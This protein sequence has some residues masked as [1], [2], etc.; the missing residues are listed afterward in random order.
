MPIKK[1][2]VCEFIT[3]G[4]LC[5]ETLP[6]SLVKEGTLIRDALLQDLSELSYEVSTTYDVRFDAPVLCATCVAVNKNDDVW[7]IWQLQMQAAD[8]VWLIAPET[9]D[10]LKKLT[11]MAEEPKLNGLQ[12]QGLSPQNIPAKAGYSYVKGPL[13]LGCGTA[14]IEVTSNK[15]ATYLALEAAGIPSIPTYNFEDWPKRHWIWLAKPN[16]GV[17]CS[18]TACFNNPDDLEDWIEDNHKQMTHV[19]Q[20]FQPGE[21][22]SISCVMRHGKAQLL[23]CNTQHIEINN[24]MLSYAGGMVNGMRDYWPQFEFIANKIAQMLPS[25]AGYVGIDVIVDDDEIIVVEINPRL[26]TTYAGMRESI[27]ANPAELV[28]NTLTNPDFVWPTLQR[29]LVSIDV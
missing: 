11:Q 17:G 26:T 12:P 14:S 22:A 27:S 16:D 13:V 5:D 25:L 7:Q 8:A 20:A 3:G 18:D 28:I 10:I 21:A 4:G 1:I 23:S 24:Q 29:N 2:F 15:M 6:E 9:G 19:I